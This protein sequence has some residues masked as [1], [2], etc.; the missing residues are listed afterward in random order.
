LFIFQLMEI[1]FFE[2]KILDFVFK[3]ILSMNR[4][5]AVRSGVSNK[6]F[7][8]A[9]IPQNLFLSQTVYVRDGKN[10]WKKNDSVFSRT[11]F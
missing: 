4:M 11:L 8:F 7:T 6:F 2:C 9:S 1:I 3:Q 10:L 5:T